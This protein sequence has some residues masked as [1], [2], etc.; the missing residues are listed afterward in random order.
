MLNRFDLQYKVM[1]RTASMEIWH[2]RMAH[3]NILHC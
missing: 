2:N 1:T 3:M